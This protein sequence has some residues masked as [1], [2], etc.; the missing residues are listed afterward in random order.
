MNIESS[1][2][3]SRTLFV[4]TI[5]TFS[6]AIAI[7]WLLPIGL[8]G[9]IVL[10][11]AILTGLALTLLGDILHVTPG[12]IVTFRLATDGL[13]A[14]QLQNGKWLDGEIAAGTMVTPY[15]VLLAIKSWNRFRYLLVFADAL[16]AD[17][18]RRLSVL[19]RWDNRPTG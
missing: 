17:E 7:A 15:W 11:F 19:L 18:F 1:L 5:A 16:Q 3:K 2:G 8:A 14:Y 12:S 13:C 10:S 9:K 6:A 4:L